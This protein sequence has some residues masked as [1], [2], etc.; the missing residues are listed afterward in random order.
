MTLKRHC[1]SFQ[2]TWFTV[3]LRFSVYLLFLE[4]GKELKVKV[5]GVHNVFR[6]HE[7]QR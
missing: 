3:F 6:H 5:T 2:V 1:F 4:I 7:C